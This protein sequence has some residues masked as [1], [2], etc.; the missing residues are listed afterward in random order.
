MFFVHLI[1]LY[2]FFL[3]ICSLCITV[4]FFFF[5]M[6]E[7]NSHNICSSRGLNNADFLFTLSEWVG[8]NRKCFPM[9]GYSSRFY[10][11]IR[12]FKVSSPV[13]TVYIACA[14]LCLVKLSL[15][16]FYSDWIYFPFEV[17]TTKWAYFLLGY[18][19]YFF[20]LKHVTITNS[21]KMQ[22]SCSTPLSGFS[23]FPGRVKKYIYINYICFKGLLRNKYG[24]L[25]I[26]NI[27]FWHVS[28]DVYKTN[29]T[30]KAS[31]KWERRR[32]RSVPVE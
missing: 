24:V 18:Y 15:L 16:P 14:S 10:Y 20:F 4:G 13:L 26:H 30:F 11:F 6:V 32:F 21:S 19:Y 23:W 12:L 1:H 5:Y 22:N 17:M 3:L 9:I 2:V 7:R 28:S 8:S 27:L 29:L 25:C 31:S